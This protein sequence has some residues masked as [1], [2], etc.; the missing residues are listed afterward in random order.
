M[1]AC[2]DAVPAILFMHVSWRARSR[3]GLELT[4]PFSLAF[5]PS[6]HSNLVQ[7]CRY[8]PLRAYYGPPFPPSRFQH[9][10][11]HAGG[12]F[13]SSSGGTASA[14][15]DHLSVPDSGRNFLISPP[16]S[17]PVGWEQIEEESPNIRTWHE[18]DEP[19]TPRT[20]QV[21][22]DE[23]SKAASPDAAWAD[24][25]ARAL[26]FLSVDAGVNDDDEEDEVEPFADGDSR[27]R[28]DGEEEAGGE[29]HLGPTTHMVLAPAPLPPFHAS[30]H[31]SAP[32]AS[33]SAIRPAV[34]VSAPVPP[35][36][37]AWDRPPTP[38]STTATPPPGA[39]KI[40]SVKATVEAMQPMRDDDV[41]TAGAEDARRSGPRFVPTAR[42]PMA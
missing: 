28:D 38:P 21:E 11:T 35:P 36:A 7:G 5:S 19:P 30:L 2:A 24:E 25:L 41:E 16:G 34:T 3:L 1:C 39:S 32:P 26:R 20:R 18:G 17:P 8:E 4:A 23:L 27:M 14:E 33:S 10:P 42:P 29:E 13:A 15:Q 37:S 22:L 40:T 6:P 12:P 9:L 31:A